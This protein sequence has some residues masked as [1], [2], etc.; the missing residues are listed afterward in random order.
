MIVKFEIYEKLI[1]EEGQFPVESLPPL[2]TEPKKMKIKKKKK[3]K[4]RT[5][6]DATRSTVL[7]LNRP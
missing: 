5:T 6:S 1:A 2:P 4:K 7:G 3:N